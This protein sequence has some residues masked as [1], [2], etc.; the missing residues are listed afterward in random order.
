MTGILRRFATA[1]ELATASAA[2][3]CEAAREAVE[4]RG[5]FCAVLPGGRTPALLFAALRDADGVVFEPQKEGLDN[6]GELTQAS[7]LC[8]ACG[9]VCPV[10]IPLPQLINRLRH[11]AVRPDTAATRGAGSR[12]AF[13]TSAMSPT[14]RIR[15]S[16][17]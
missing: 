4:A 8:G 5:R 16:A 12:A 11:D 3:F 6:L 1:S 17:C 14:R 9:E 10:R 13:D 2:L 15:P 7:S